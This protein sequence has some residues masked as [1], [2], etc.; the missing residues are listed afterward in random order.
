MEIKP[1]CK[2]VVTT[3]VNV[4]RVIDGKIVEHGGAANLLHSMLD[5]GAITLNK[6]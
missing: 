5:I 6:V 1:T 4:D 3:G 2:K